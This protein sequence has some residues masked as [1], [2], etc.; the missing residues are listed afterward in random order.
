MLYFLALIPATGL[1]LAG[2]LVLVL[3]ARTE[4]GMRAF[5]RYLGFW[6]F[7]LAALVILGAILAAAHG[8]HR[9]FG[10][11]GGMHCPWQD[12]ARFAPRPAE[13]EGPRSPAAPDG[14]AN[15]APPAAPPAPR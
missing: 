8:G 3:S 15:P 4:G 14:A 7:T 13:P 6:A 1:V 2:Y 10:A 5:G 12:G 9:G 11:H